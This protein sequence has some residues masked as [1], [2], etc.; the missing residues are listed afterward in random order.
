ME[1][2]DG[3]LLNL[4][5][6]PPP[7]TKKNKNKSRNGSSKKRA[8]VQESS[9]D[10][11]AT[12]K[13]T[14]GLSGAG[15]SSGARRQPSPTI[16]IPKESTLSEEDRAAIIKAR[17][18]SLGSS[19]K[20]TSSHDTAPR[21]KGGSHGYVSSLFA[22]DEAGASEPA[23][24]PETPRSAPSN[25]PSSNASSFEALG[26][27]E[28]L[29]THLRERM[30]ID[31]K[32][33][34]IQRL[35]I[36]PLISEPPSPTSQRD[37]LIQAQ[38]GS[39]KT[40]TYL[41][42]IVQS[43]LPFS[44]ESYIDRSIGTLA[45][46]L[47]PTRELAR[48]IY[49][50]LE[51]LLTMSLTSQHEAADGTLLRRRA[52]WIVPNLL[53]GG[54]TKNHEKQRIRKGSPIIV[55]T[56]G[57]LLDHLQNTSSLDVGKCR[58]L[59]LDEADRL[60]EMGFEEQLSGIVKALDGRRRLSVSTAREALLNNGAIEPHAPDSQVTDSLGVAWWAW[61]RRV[62]LC[63][64]TLDERVQVFSGTTLHQ[65][66]LI[67][68]G[69][70]QAVEPAPGT[71]HKGTSGPTSDSAQSVGNRTAEDHEPASLNAPV[72]FNGPTFSAPAQ[73]AQHAVIVPPKLRLVTLL[74]LLR[75]SLP[76]A[77]EA[78][79]PARVM[80]FLTCTDTVDFHWHAIGG[81]RMG[82]LPTKDSVTSR[83]LPSSQD[84]P[85][86]QKSDLLPGVP[87]YRLHGSM[88]Q[89]E[90]IA[91]LRAFHTLEDGT[92]A[93]PAKRGGVLLCTSVAS[94][95][96]D[97]PHVSCVIQMDVP[98][99]GGVEEYVHRVGRTAR[100]GR[101]GTSWL[102][103]MPH[104]KPWLDV[105]TQRMV[106][107]EPPRRASVPVVGY[108]TVL[109]EGFGGAAREYESRATDVQM[110]LERW[111]LADPSHAS[112]ARTAFLAHIRAY[113]THP[114][115]EKAIFHVNQLHLGHVAKAFAL[116]EAPQTVQRTAKKEHERQT[117]PKA[118]EK[119]TEIRRQ[120]ML[121]NLP[122]ESM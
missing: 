115:S 62:V 68:A 26:L 52:R 98:T 25:A 59:V 7:S 84:M 43:L 56:P 101:E 28:I 53:T 116:R 86:A 1:G 61:R 31:G 2:D 78:A 117:Q 120:R 64:A 82:Q 17:A 5:A 72:D 67:R 111:V 55:S 13:R 51:R 97:L 40:L 96:L 24:L 109:Y 63:S 19:S 14:R 75:Q 3:L 93:A 112:L 48:Q 79:H 18:M 58:W 73:L 46:I 108:D 57:R 41:L 49:Q 33:T 38:T 70:H 11:A 45:I 90:R 66:L 6:A 50:V 69:M 87:I 91:S 85:L 121:A 37:V 103:L 54:S 4:D 10:D 89:K 12:T 110:A 16:S 20:T 94:R 74:A 106:V 29:A 8:L 23:G 92:D 83:P 95:G 21:S 34:D 36:P 44:E 9:A 102:M 114:A 77:S 42:P 118:P 22:R 105:L 30:G 122:T 39:G 119:D 27:D 100:V 35:A 47:A 88:T 60:L 32:P 76:R 113:A 15:T 104:E 71:R 81:A 65:P 107:G 80:V 99:E